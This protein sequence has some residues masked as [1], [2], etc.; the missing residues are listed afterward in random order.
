VKLKCW[1]RK[2]FERAQIHGIQ[3]KMAEFQQIVS[4]N[5]LDSD[6]RLGIQKIFSEKQKILANFRKSFLNSA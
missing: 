6:V 5:L 2:A 1:T 4:E 3:K